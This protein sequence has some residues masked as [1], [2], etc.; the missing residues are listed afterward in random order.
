MNE[1]RETHD[2][3]PTFC[4]NMIVK[5]EAHCIQKCLT[6]VANL[7]DS[8]RII[9][10]GSVD[11]TCHVI[12]EF[13]DL[14]NIPGEVLD[15]P[16]LEFGPSRTM[17]LRE[18]D[19][20]ADY[21]LFMDADDYL[22]NELHPNEPVH[23]EQLSS[24]VRD[25]SKEVYL[26][27]T[28]TGSSIYARPF[29]CRPDCGWKWKGVRHEGLY[30]P[31]GSPYTHGG[32]LAAT[33]HTET[34]FEG[35]RSKGGMEAKYASDAAVMVKEFSRRRSARELFYIAQSFKDAHFFKLATILYTARGML[36]DDD[37]DSRYMAL[38]TAGLIYEQKLAQ[39]DKAT[40]L[41]MHADQIRPCRHEAAY[42]IAESLY[43]R[44]LVLAAQPW[45]AAAKAKPENVPDAFCY[46][47]TMRNDSIP[48]LYEKLRASPSTGQ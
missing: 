16:W 6:S 30:P 8:Y 33:F 11:G 35:A 45:I 48:K 26:L 31:K 24:L 25:T 42:S 14:R 18:C 10:T 12:R 36:P 39:P 9:D 17:A 32:I 2:D 20:V 44:G 13:M 22:I 38:Y 47:L 29:L 34:A 43:K 3:G 4:L 40:E 7:I 37:M 1:L 28:R 19:G 23:K 46:D 5:D 15:Y 21:A 27:Y 41:W